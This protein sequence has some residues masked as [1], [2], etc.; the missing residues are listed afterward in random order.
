MSSDDL[1]IRL[2]EKLKKRRP[3]LTDNEIEDILSRSIR[4]SSLIIE[5]FHRK[6]AN[7][8]NDE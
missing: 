6:S 7:P 5:S 1:A 4:L 8:D 2:R 3:E